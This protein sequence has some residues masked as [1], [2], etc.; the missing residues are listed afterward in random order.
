VDVG[1]RFAEV[2]KESKTFIPAD[3]LTEELERLTEEYERLRPEVE[4][5]LSIKDL[6][7]DLQVEWRVLTHELEGMREFRDK[8]E[9]DPKHPWTHVNAIKVLLRKL[10]E[11]NE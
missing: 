3:M 7:D 4:R 6:L 8:W 10:K 11:V 9:D 2:I 1:R 5:V